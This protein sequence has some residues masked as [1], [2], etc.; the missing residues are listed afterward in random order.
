[1]IIMFWFISIDIDNKIYNIYK[2]FY[3]KFNWAAC[4]VNENALCGS[5]WRRILSG[6]NKN[7]LSRRADWR[8]PETASK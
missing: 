2:Q 7:H 1:M 3:I 4:M 6:N 8:T 5:W